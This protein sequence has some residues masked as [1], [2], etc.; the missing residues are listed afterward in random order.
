MDRAMNRLLDASPAPSPTTP[1]QPP[2]YQPAAP[3]LQDVDDQ[4]MQLQKAMAASMAEQQDPTRVRAGTPEDENLMRV[5]AESI[6]TET[7]RTAEDTFADSFHRA[8]DVHGF[9]ALVPQLATHR[10]I[11]AALQALFAAPLAKEA[12]TT[13]SPPD[14]RTADIQGYWRGE[15][16]TATHA[17]PPASDALQMVQRVQTAFT[18]MA[19]TQRA[20]LILGDIAP[21]IPRD[22]Q[23]QISKNAPPHT[24]LELYL[25]ALVQAYLDVAHMCANEITLSTRNETAYA[26][27]QYI[28][29]RQG[30][31]QSFAA[32][33]LPSDMPTDQ[34]PADAQPTSTITLTQ[35]PT[36]DFVYACMF[37]K[38]AAGPE[39]DSLLITRPADILLL[40]IQREKNV[41]SPFLIEEVVYLDRFL[42]E[43]QRGAKIDLDPRWH[44]LQGWQQQ[45]AA[46]AARKECML[47]PSKTPL[48]PLLA[49]AEAHFTEGNVSEWLGQVHDA[50]DA[51]IHALDMELAALQAQIHATQ[52]ALAQTLAHEA[53]DPAMHTVPYDLCA[54]IM[55]GAD[56]CVYARQG[57]DWFCIA[58][59]T[60]NPT[61]FEAIRTDAR[62]IDQG[63][64]VV[65]LVYTRRAATAPLAQTPA[66]A[67]LHAAVQQ[68]NARAAQEW[69]H[70]VHTHPL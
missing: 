49:R 20:A 40:N 11:A 51:Q 35:T 5:L 64:G 58:N 27:A 55:A 8:R 48:Y 29:A 67:T 3:A 42:W 54:C 68:D 43:K 15:S 60:C 34:A 47:A 56:D 10:I 46:A 38:L 50:I 22:V 6:Q 12:F 24:V 2:A 69:S 28:A 26:R 18:F 33:A 21:T 61:S 63:L 16:L 30:L 41:T 39:M 37:A 19:T 23:Y 13:A 9:V 57:E 62:G 7:H 31:F 53:A 14:P 32:P 1:A 36:N 52:Q 17:S 45:H 66:L 44:T 4:D 59:G 25:D 65:H 70:T